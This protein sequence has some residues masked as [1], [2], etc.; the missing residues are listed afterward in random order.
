ML[1]RSL[2]LMFCVTL[3]AGMA[4]VVPVMARPARKSMHPEHPHKGHGSRAGHAHRRH[5]RSRPPVTHKRGDMTKTKGNRRAD[6]I[7]G[8]ARTGVAAATTDP[9]SKVPSHLIW[10]EEF[11]GPAGGSPN[12]NNWNF[13]TGG[14]GWGNEELE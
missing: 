8:T 13:D 5:K 9:T 4:V 10:S 1:R 11:N 14:K 2:R 6:T 3:T 12:P 7:L